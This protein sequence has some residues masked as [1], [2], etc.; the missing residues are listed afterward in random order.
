M[1]AV[2]AFKRL[3][4]EAIGG[5]PAVGALQRDRH[6]SLNPDCRPHQAGHDIADIVCGPCLK[7]KHGRRRKGRS[8]LPSEKKAPLRSGARLSE[9]SGDD[10]QIATPGTGNGATLTM[11][12]KRLVGELD[13]SPILWGWP[14]GRMDTGSRRPSTPR[15]SPDAERRIATGYRIEGNQGSAR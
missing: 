1:T 11:T 8:E 15:A 14:R 2:S 3:L 13:Q 7:S 9:G 6:L 10:R 12:S 5:A 4:E